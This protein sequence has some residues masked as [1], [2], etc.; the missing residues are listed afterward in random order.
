MLSEATQYQVT[1]VAVLPERQVERCH[2]AQQKSG[3]C[4]T[5]VLIDGEFRMFPALRWR[6]AHHSKK[7]RRQ[8]LPN[9]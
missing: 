7:L 5:E 8:K 6:E 9:R 1:W 2:S 3:A 4:S